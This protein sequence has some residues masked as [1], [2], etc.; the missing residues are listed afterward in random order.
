MAATK[1]VKEALWLKGLVGDLGVSQN[2]ITA[3]CDSQ[4]AIH[5]IKNQM[6]HKRTKNID[7]RMHFISDVTT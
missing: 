6:Y 3:F 2:E 7:V 4:S 5:L 1:A